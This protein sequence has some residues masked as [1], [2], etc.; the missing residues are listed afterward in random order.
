MRP[1]HVLLFLLPLIVLYEVG[2]ALFL[3]DVAA[4]TRETIKA[5]RLMGDFFNVFGIAGLFMPGVALVTVLLVWQFLSGDRWVVRWNTI[6]GMAAECVAWTLPLVVLSAASRSA[7]NMAPSGG[8]DPMAALNTWMAQVG[9]G[10]APGLEALSW[11]AKLSI[12]IGAGLY[13][14]MLFR[15]VGIALIHFVLRDLL[16]AREVASSVL[17]VVG[18]A[19]IFALYHD[20]SNPAGSMNYFVFGFLTLAGCFLGAVYVLRGFGIVVGTHALYDIVVLVLLTPGA[21]GHG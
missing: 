1:L 5:Y 20:L 15:L 8:I 21:H 12:S 13:E 14:E 16:G 7:A 10:P 9:P 2:S 17:A 11:Q 18:S 3:A 6:A 4:G 19:V